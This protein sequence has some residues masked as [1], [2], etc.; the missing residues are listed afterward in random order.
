MNISEIELPLIVAKT[1]G[2]R[3]KNRRTVTYQFIDS[4]YPRLCLDK[5]DLILAQLE[6]CEML[7]EY[8]MDEDKNTVESEV[9]E[10]K[11]VMVGLVTPVQRAAATVGSPSSTG[12]ERA[13]L[14]LHVSV[15]LSISS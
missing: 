7:L 14:Q 6:A 10:L 8:V 13:H 4:S 9:T 15:N 2:C 11:M 12:R 5:K 3:E 1:C